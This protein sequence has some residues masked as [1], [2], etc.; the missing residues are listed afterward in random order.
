M[1]ARER[2][3]QKITA[4]LQT[5]QVEPLFVHQAPHREV[6]ILCE[7]KAGEREAAGA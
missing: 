6:G 5:L 4:S 2:H 1:E 7:R 3:G